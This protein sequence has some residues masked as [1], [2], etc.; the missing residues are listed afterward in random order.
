[1]D[2]VELSEWENTMPILVPHSLGE[3]PLYLPS[4]YDAY[5]WHVDNA[6]EV[7]D[8]LHDTINTLAESCQIGKC[9]CL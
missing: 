7:C 2:V 4:K 1:M 9:V 8:K 5:L 3:E 6:K